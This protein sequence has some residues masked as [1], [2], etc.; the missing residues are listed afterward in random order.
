MKLAKKKLSRLISLMALFC[1]IFSLVIPYGSFVEAKNKPN[2]S[3]TNTL[4]CQ[5]IQ[6]NYLEVYDSVTKVTNSSY[7]ADTNP[8]IN[9]NKLQGHFTVTNTF[10]GELYLVF[11]DSVCTNYALGRQGNSKQFILNNIPNKGPYKLYVRENDATA[12]ILT[13]HGIQNITLSSA[14]VK[15]SSSETGRVHYVVLPKT[16]PA[17]TLEEIKNGSNIPV[18]AYY[19]TLIS[20]S[21]L[22]ANTDYK[23]YLIAFDNAGNVSAMQSREFKTIT[24]LSEASLDFYVTPTQTNGY[25]INKDTG[26]AEGELNAE[27]I[28]KGLVSSGNR[29]TPIDVVFIFDTSGSM[30]LDT[31]NPWWSKSDPEKLQKAKDAA[32]NAIEKFKL[33]VIPGDRFA[34]VSFSSEVNIVKEF[35][36]ST[37][38]SAVKTQLDG[39]KDTI[40]N[41]NANGGTDYQAALLKAKEMLSNSV[42]SKY[43]VFLTD[44]TPT[45]GSSVISKNVSGYFRKENSFDYDHLKNV[46]VSIREKEYSTLFGPIKRL[47]F[48]YNSKTY[49]YRDN[50]MPYLAGLE[51]ATELAKNNIELFS[52]GLGSDVDI[53]YLKQLSKLTGGYALLGEKDDLQTI[54]TTITEEINQ[55]ALRDVKVKIKVKNA[56]LPGNVGLKE[57]TNDEEES[58]DSVDLPYMDGDYAVLSFGDIQYEL[59]GPTPT[60]IEKEISLLFDTAG[61]YTFND[62]KLS[63]IDLKGDTKVVGSSLNVLIKNNNVAPPIATGGV[64]QVSVTGAE[65]EANIKLYTKDNVELDNTKE[66]LADAE[67]KFTFTNV[68]PGRDY[69]V[70][71][72]LN[73]LES[74]QSNKVVVKPANINATAGNKSID[75]DLAEPSAT[76]TLYQGTTAI[77]TITAGPNGKGTFPNVETGT[78][79][80]TQTVNSVESDSVEVTVEEQVTGLKF[81]N[82]SYSIKVNDS[83]DMYGQLVAIPTGTTKPDATSPNWT[84]KTDNKSI[85]EVDKEGKI[86][87]IKV[88]TTTITAKYK[89]IEARVLVRVT[90][91]SGGSNNSEYEN[92]W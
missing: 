83:K 20:L 56:N 80:V 14:D 60:P 22:A 28:P 76:L 54:Y 29:Q 26:L 5:E 27:V 58:I 32:S 89:G 84:W 7:I 36:T 62:V 91:G 42:N 41:L 13:I 74:G 16:Q 4:T 8:I 18:Y 17:P 78:Y 50:D 34:F 37:D 44:G 59:N 77:K 70:T 39:I 85:V 3:N 81:R 61:I 82:A 53:E 68:P 86:K 64:N 35:N 72:T 12:P 23:V 55:V 9:D 52:I 19:P 25:L 57:Y 30:V 87:G 79:T 40:S 48:D 46:A 92:Q 47:V 38:I 31:S 45:E 66:N 88:G 11:N 49:I 6:T 51:S 67:G 43:V 1:L 15:V 69:Y 75:V 65:P 63:Y 71:Q 2:T 10:E 21:N 33:N 90:S 73:N 24:A